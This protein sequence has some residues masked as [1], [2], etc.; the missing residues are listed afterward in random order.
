MG[1][2]PNLSLA[3]LCLFFSLPSAAQDL[4]PFIRLS[5]DE[6]AKAKQLVQSLKDAQERSSEAKVARGQFHQLYQAAHP[7]LKGLKFADDFRLAI[8]RADNAAPWVFHAASIE[9]TAEERKKLEHLHQE[10]T[11]SE[12]SQKQAE[13]AWKD[14][15]YQLIADHVTADHAAGYSDVTLSCGKQIRMYMPWT[16]M[17]V[18]T[19]DFKLPFPSGSFKD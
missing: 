2:V 10:M 13:N 12:Q 4:V 18:F 17:L 9:L 3:I 7:D 6:V 15:N 11:E 19:A 1:R 5:P 14:F 8:A 16:G